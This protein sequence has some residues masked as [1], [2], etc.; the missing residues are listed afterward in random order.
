MELTLRN[1]KASDLD[2]ICGAL[3]AEGL[4]VDGV[5]AHLDAFFVCE[6]GGRFGGAA[7]LEVHGDDGL[8]RSVVVD[9]GFRRHG[10]GRQLCERVMTHAG[11]K[12]CLAVYLLTL[13][14]AAY[15]E[16]LGFRVIKRDEAPPGIRAS[17]EFS[18]L[19]PDTAVLMRR[20][21]KS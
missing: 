8:L 3:R 7:G 14:A 2:A 9:P 19:C 5:E 4:P 13:D 1:A 18:S 10:A 12:G 17:E 11:S 15:F 20:S 21:V 16:R 6:L